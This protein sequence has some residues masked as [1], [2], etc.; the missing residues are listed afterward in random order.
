[1]PTS[2]CGVITDKNRKLNT[3]MKKH[4]SLKTM[5]EDKELDAVSKATSFQVDPR[6]LKVKPGFNGRPIDPKHVR[7]MVEGWKNGATFP[8]IEVS[9]EDGEVFI[10]DGHHRH[11]SA[12]VAIDEGVE[13]KRIDARHFR[14]DEDDRILLMI[15]SQQGLPLTPLQ[16]GVQYARLVALGWTHAEIAAR[17]GKTAQHV[18][19]CIA[20]TEAPLDVRKMLERGQVSADVVRK[21]VK[22]HGSAAGDVLRDDLAKAKEAGKEKVTAGSAST[23]PPSRLS[24]A[25]A[26]LERMRDLLESVDGTTLENNKLVNDYR[27]FMK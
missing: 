11:A 8:P 2:K 22:Q 21:T 9:V 14:G 3:M 1:M 18:R 27:A 19:D 25:L 20:L 23:K 7:Q 24:T 4:V 15:T 13:I 16:L 6:H 5:A 12:L 26:L 10:V 17:P